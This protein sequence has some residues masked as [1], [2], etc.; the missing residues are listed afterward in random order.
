MMSFLS[1]IESLITYNF[2]F[3][4]IVDKLLLF[5]FLYFIQLLTVLLL[6]ILYI[7]VLCNIGVTFIFIFRFASNKHKFDLF[8]ANFV[9]FFM[10]TLVFLIFLSCQ[11]V[12]LSS[13]RRMPRVVLQLQFSISG[14]N[15]FQGNVPRHYLASG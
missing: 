12:V 1:K 3:V 8:P 7:I 5:D 14:L 15:F 13:K 11:F 4:I 9:Q 10:L 2:H 6:M